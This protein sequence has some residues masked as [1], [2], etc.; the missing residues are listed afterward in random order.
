MFK[1]IYINGPKQASFNCQSL[2][3]Y[4][5]IGLLMH[6]IITCGMLNWLMS[7]FLQVIGTVPGKVVKKYQWF[8]SLKAYPLNVKRFVTLYSNKT[9]K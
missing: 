7:H 3:S 5:Y 4:E 6:H 1:K 9:V 2:A 8:I